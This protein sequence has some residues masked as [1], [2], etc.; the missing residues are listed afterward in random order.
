MGDFVGAGGISVASLLSHYICF[1]KILI[2]FS[3]QAVSRWFS[4]RGYKVA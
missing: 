4:L 1:V 2:S 3:L